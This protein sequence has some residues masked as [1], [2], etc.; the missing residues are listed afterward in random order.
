MIRSERKP[1][2][3]GKRLRYRLEW[4]AAAA[5]ARIVPLFP[6]PFIVKLGRA[7]GRLA[8]RGE[9]RRVALENLHVAFGN[10]KPLTE[11]ERIARESLQSFGATFLGLFWGRR[12]T[13]VNFRGERNFRTRLAATSD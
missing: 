13:P 9:L 2:T 4:L 12:L 5:L 10:T 8:F 11:K 3:A 6:R 1:V 7:L